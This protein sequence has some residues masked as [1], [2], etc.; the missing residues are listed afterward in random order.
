[1][2]IFGEIQFLKLTGIDVPEHADVCL[3]VPDPEG[4][5]QGLFVQHLTSELPGQRL[6]VT[7]PEQ[8]PDEIETQTPSILK[9]INNNKKKKIF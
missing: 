1:M 5:E 2:T 8:Q 9:F 6:E 3:H 7:V 4:V